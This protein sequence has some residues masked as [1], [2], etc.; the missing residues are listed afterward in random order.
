MGKLLVGDKIENDVKKEYRIYNIMADLKNKVK[1]GM[2][3]SRSHGYEK[4]EGVPTPCY[5]TFHTIRRYKRKVYTIC[6]N[7]SF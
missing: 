2:D 4:A 1:K 7:K 3:L 5:V 6:L